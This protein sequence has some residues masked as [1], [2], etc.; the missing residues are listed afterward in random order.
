MPLHA[1]ELP[2]EIWLSIFAYFEGHD[3][4]RSFSGLNSFFNSLLRSPHLRLHMRMKKDESNER[5][6]ESTW[7]HINRENIYS[8]AVGRRKANCLIQFL[9]WHAQYLTRL[10]SLSVY[11]RKLNSYYNIQF[12][13]FAL[14]QLPALKQLRIKYTSKINSTS[15]EL[16]PLMASLFNNRFIIPNYSLVFDMSE[17]KI[18][19]S[20]W[21]INPYLTSLRF[22]C[23]SVNNLLS[24]LPFTPQLHSLTLQLTS[25]ST[26]LYPN[27]TFD[28]L[29]KLELRLRWTPFASLQAFRKTMP[30]LR[31]L[32]LNGSMEGTDEN[33]C[34]ENLWNKLLNN[35]EYF[36][37]KLSSFAYD[38]RK[39][40]I[41]KDLIQNLGEKS[42]FSHKETEHRITITIQFQ[43]VRKLEHFY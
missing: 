2:P 26:P 27:I 25:S 1:E 37:V 42:W 18:D 19:T 28:H 40:T 15:D 29:Q 22:D 32:I 14:G 39:K 13:V 31:V 38:E 8:L 6:P 11:L 34:K 43:S 41:F 4:V 7:A 9:R 5:L 35:I 3:L 16:Q 24:L 33:Y 30:N 36:R 20:T 21:S 23:I 17:Y 12:L 10:T